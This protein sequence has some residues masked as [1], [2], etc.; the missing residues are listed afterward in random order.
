MEFG[1]NLIELLLWVLGIGGEFCGNVA[2]YRDLLIRLHGD[3]DQR[4]IGT[5]ELIYLLAHEQRVVT[6]VT[7]NS[8]RNRTYSE[9][10]SAKSLS[11]ALGVDGFSATAPRTFSE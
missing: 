5:E 3:T 1:D 7:H 2:K 9:S 10:S 4:A 6:V 8:T 11:T